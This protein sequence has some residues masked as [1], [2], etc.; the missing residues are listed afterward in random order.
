MRSRTHPQ[1]ILQVAELLPQVLEGSN[2]KVQLPVTCKSDEFAKH[3]VNAKCQEE[4]T[5]SQTTLSL[6]AVQC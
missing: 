3:P 5:N 2:S 6:S 4:T 1:V